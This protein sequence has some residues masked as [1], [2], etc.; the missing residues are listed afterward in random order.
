MDELNI[1][2]STK[3]MRGFVATVISRLILKKLGHQAEIQ[4]NELSAETTK[5]VKIRI[6]VNAD[7]EM[8]LSEFTQMIKTI[9][10]K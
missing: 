1:N 2:V 5:D 10:L 6:H 8:A 7:A 9:W 3:I 4:I